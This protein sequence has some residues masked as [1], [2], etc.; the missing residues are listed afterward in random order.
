VVQ[1]DLDHPGASGRGPGRAALK[2]L[3]TV[4]RASGGARGFGST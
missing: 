2:A 4:V 3:K 1:G